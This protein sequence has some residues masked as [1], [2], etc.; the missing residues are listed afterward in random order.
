[1]FEGLSRLLSQPSKQVRQIRPRPDSWYIKKGFARCVYCG[2]WAKAITQGNV[3]P[4][5]M[6]CEDMSCPEPEG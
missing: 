5:C 2:G 1:M 6:R 3:H 4:V